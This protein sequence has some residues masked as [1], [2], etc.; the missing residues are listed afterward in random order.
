MNV[1]NYTGWGVHSINFKVTYYRLL[2][3]YF[4]ISLKFLLN[5]PIVI[6]ILK[7]PVLN[8]KYD[9]YKIFIY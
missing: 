3:P 7:N 1:Q 2:F 5:N 9:A 6:E 8:H 4:T